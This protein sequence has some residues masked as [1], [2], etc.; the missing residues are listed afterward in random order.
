VRRVIGGLRNEAWEVPSSLLAGGKDDGHHH[1]AI[2][3]CVDVMFRGLMGV[4]L[5]LV[6]EQGVEAI[7]WRRIPTT[8]NTFG[9]QMGGGRAAAGLGDVFPA[10]R[11]QI[12]ITTRR[13]LIQLPR[14]RVARR[15]AVL[16]DPFGREQFDGYVADGLWAGGFSCSI[17]PT[18]LITQYWAVQRQAV[19]TQA[20]FGQTSTLAYGNAK[21]V[22]QFA[23]KL[24]F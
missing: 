23:V 9:G 10:R 16:H 5:S 14:S 19:T 3:A 17:I 4:G 15:R 1:A 7:S 11:L 8:W 20:S 22:L 18:S 24:Q 21:R 13:T 2:R 6:P 12:S